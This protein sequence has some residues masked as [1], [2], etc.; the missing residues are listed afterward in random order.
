MKILKIMTCLLVLGTVIS[1]TEVSKNTGP[2]KTISDVHL[3]KT[4]HHK[5]GHK[6]KGHHPKKDGD[7]MIGMPN[8]ASVYCTEQGGESVTKKDEQGNEYGICKFKDGKEVDEWQFYR[9][10]HE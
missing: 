3:E 7:R 10:N 5:G 1:C 9:E 6:K 8:P 4:G 2:E